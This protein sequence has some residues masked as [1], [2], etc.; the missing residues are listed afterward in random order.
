M[1]TGLLVPTYLVPSTELVLNNAYVYNAILTLDLARNTAG[2][3]LNVHQ[4]KT[5]ADRGK[6]PVHT[7]TV[8]CGQPLLD[9]SGDVVYTVPTL[10]EIR[11]TVATG[12]TVA[13]PAA[14][15]GQDALNILLSILLGIWMNHPL[16]KN[17]TPT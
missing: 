11:A 9:A 5:K 14:P 2:L 13:N 8:E 4:N 6:M 17:S 15:T 3:A 12:V 1:P 10:D 16:L 7:L